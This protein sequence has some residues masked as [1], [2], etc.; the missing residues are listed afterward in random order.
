MSRLEESEAVQMQTNSAEQDY[1][2]VIRLLEAEIKDLKEKL[3][4]KK[5]TSLQ[6]MNVSKVPKVRIKYP[7]TY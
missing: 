5:H 1:E 4:E 7:T 2:E 3:A 6:V